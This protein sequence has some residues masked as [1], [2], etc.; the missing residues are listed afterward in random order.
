[1]PPL[2]PHSTHAV[3]PYVRF[4]ARRDVTDASWAAAFIQIAYV[5]Y[6]EEG[7][8][9]LARSYYDR[10]LLQL[11]VMAARVEEAGGLGRLQTPHGDWCPPPSKPGGTPDPRKPEN[12]QQGPKPPPPVTSAFSYILMVQEVAELAH[13]L[14]NSTEHARLSKLALHLMAEYNH[15]FFRFVL[16]EPCHHTGN[17]TTD[18]PSHPYLS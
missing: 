5:L 16:I 4:G 17:N 3:A 7:D 9:S 10:F 1:M 2:T 12:A 15:A 6:K 18:L 14:G 8:L 13:A 11:G